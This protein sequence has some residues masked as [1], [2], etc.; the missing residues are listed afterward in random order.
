[1]VWSIGLSTIVLKVEY[2][3][4]TEG[5][6]RGFRLGYLEESDSPALVVEDRFQSSHSKLELTLFVNPVSI[7]MHRSSRH[8]NA[9]T[10]PHTQPP[11]STAPTAL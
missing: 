7:I 5:F 9:T 8:S 4:R 1:M 2:G 11:S 3:R 6:V 10:H